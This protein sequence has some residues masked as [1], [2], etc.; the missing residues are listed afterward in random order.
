M[1]TTN[2]TRTINHLLNH[3]YKVLSISFISISATALIVP[4][5]AF[6][7]TDPS[8]EAA[9]DFYSFNNVLFYAPYDQVNCIPDTGPGLGTLLPT[10]EISP[11]V[12]NTRSEQIWN[13]LITKGLSPQQAAGV[14]GNIQVE[15]AGTYDPGI[16]E[17]EANIYG[18]KGYGIAQWT[19]SRRDALV[20]AAAA[21]SV[22]VNDLAF[23]L[24]FMY[25]E[26]NTRKVSATV[27]AQGY[28]VR[29][30]NEWETLKQQASIL[31]A[32]VFWH[33]NFE[34]SSQSPSAVISSRGSAA[35]AVY[36]LYAAGAA[37][38]PGQALSRETPTTVNSDQVLYACP[39]GTHPAYQTGPSGVSGAPSQSAQSILET[40]TKFAWPKD[41]TGL[42]LNS[43][44]KPEYRQAAYDYFPGYGDYTL[45]DCT[46]FVATVMRASGADASFPIGTIP[47]KN[48]LTGN[49]KYDIVYNPT[50]ADLQPG[51]ILQHTN[52][53]TVAGGGTYSGH[54]MFYT[55]NS[56]DST[57]A[58]PG[59]DAS[60]YTRVPGYRPQ[61]SIDS[62]LSE[63]TAY[64]ARLK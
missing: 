64:R 23:Q 17:F 18:T 46:Y 50:A 25:Q 14:M 48:Y 52:G 15:T 44:A 27:A 5:S 61:R 30:E 22:P 37:D 43:D 35:Q 2:Q 13:F 58:F 19:G 28:G 16:E 20:A 56:L 10:M 38:T 51:D 41:T 21:A 11:L 63:S 33:N 47:I 40:I 3:L 42:K 36:N 45:A 4:V 59:A 57:G 24:E 54:I 7:I 9:K 12:G 49:S 62:M 60:K 26:S 6:A 53:G 32:V 8:S 34:V 39:P 1:T 55:G 31:D 29:G